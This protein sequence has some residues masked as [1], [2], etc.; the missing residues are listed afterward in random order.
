MAR[1]RR[2]V[3]RP[4]AGDRVA[5]RAPPILQ[6]LCSWRLQE[7]AP[8]D[9]RP[10][11]VTREEADFGV[12]EDLFGLYATAREAFAQTGR[13]AFPVPAAKRSAAAKPDKPC[14]GIKIPSVPRRLHRQG[15]G[16]AAQCAPDDGA[17]KLK[18]KP[19]PMPGR[20]HSSSATNSGMM[21]DFH[22]FD[23]WRYLRLGTQRRGAPSSP[24]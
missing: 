2:R 18:L 10:T 13:G 22:L 20:W 4:L 11:L 12:D 16:V 6:E 7:T 8:G 19:W 24:F 1:R 3:R 14:A 9:F 17:G 5:T 23:R 15:A 21:E